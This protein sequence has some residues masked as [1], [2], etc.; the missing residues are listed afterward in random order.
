MLKYGVLLV[1]PVLAVL[2][3]GT[4]PD[5]NIF[6]TRHYHRLFMMLTW[7]LLADLALISTRYLKYLM[8]TNRVYLITHISLFLLIF[9]SSG[10]S[11]LVML[12][13]WPVQ[14]KFLNDTHKVYYFRT[15]I[16]VG[17]LHFALL[18]IQVILGIIS[19]VTINTRAYP[20]ATR[21]LIYHRFFGLLIFLVAKGMFLIGNM[22]NATKTHVDY[23]WLV[24]LFCE[25]VLFLVL[26]TLLRQG[27][28][29]CA[30]S[31]VL[32]IWQNKLLHEVQSNNYL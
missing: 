13:S 28:L 25:A 2:S 24:I 23:L 18:L 21:M 11:S 4:S 16:V 26:E 27:R 30:A 14:H 6:T 15:H 9:L 7:G 31:G 17:A 12:L 20:K 19:R 22:T 8:P 10:L 29:S 32:T 5:W 1:I 3:N